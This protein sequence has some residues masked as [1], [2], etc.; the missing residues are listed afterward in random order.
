[1]PDPEEPDDPDMPDPEEP[2]VPVWP[3]CPL[4]PR[5]PLMPERLVSPA[6]SSEADEERL[7]PGAL[8]DLPSSADSSSRIPPCDDEP[9]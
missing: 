3:L 5:W 2:D 1:M 9:D 8:R 7:L 4:W 6:S